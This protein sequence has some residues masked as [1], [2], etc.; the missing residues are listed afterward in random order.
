M[1]ISK[2]SWTNSLNS[3]L[4]TQPSAGKKKKKLEKSNGKKIK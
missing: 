2:Y 3:I 4:N 1:K